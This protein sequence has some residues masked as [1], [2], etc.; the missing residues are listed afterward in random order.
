[1]LKNVKFAK[2]LTLDFLKSRG[3]VILAISNLNKHL[4]TQKTQTQWQP[5]TFSTKQKRQVQL[6]K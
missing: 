1:M 5:Q 2:K 4:T 6:K 3:F